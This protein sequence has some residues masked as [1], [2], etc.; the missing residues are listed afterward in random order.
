MNIRIAKSV[1][2]A[3]L[4]CGGG[5]LLSANETT[6]LDDIQVVTTASG[7]EQ[8][9]T[10]A[11]AS[12]SVI[13]QEDLQKKSFTSILDAVANIEGVDINET[14]DKSGQGSISIRGMGGNYTLILI[15]GKR[16]NNNGGLYP[17]GNGG[18]QSANI[19]PQ[20]M[21]ERVEV[22]RGPMSTLYGADAMGGVINIIT[23]K[24]TKTWTGSINH[25]R[26]FQGER[27]W[28]DENSTDFA[29]S[30]PIIKDKLGLSLRG[31]YLDKDRGNPEYKVVKKPDGTDEDRNDTVWNADGKTLDTK[32]YSLGAGLTFTPTDV[33]TI[34]VDYDINKQRYDHSGEE[35]GPVDSLDWIFDT[36]K[37][38]YRDIQRMEREQYSAS[39]E[40]DWDIG[41]S[42]LLIHHI[43]TN[44]FG[45]SMPLSPED[46]L[47]IVNKYPSS[48]GGTNTRPN[49]NVLNNAQYHAD[50]AAAMNDPWF[51]AFMPRD[52]RTLK[53]ETT[54]Y[55]AKYELPL[56]S[57]F[58]TV[59]TEYLDREMA[60]GIWSQPGTLNSGGAVQKA[61]QWAVFAEDNW[62]IIDPLTL[63]LGARYTKDENFGGHFSPRAYL[64]YSLNDNWTFKGGV[65]TGYKTPELQQLVD[66]IMYYSGHGTAPAVGNPNLDPETSVN[67]EAAVYYNH[68]DGHNFNVTLFQN[69]FKDKIETVDLAQTSDNFLL[70]DVWKNNKDRLPTAGKSGNTAYQQLE[71]VGKAT[72][73]GIEIAGKYYI[74]DNLS[75][76][77]N[78]TFL[79]TE[80]K[81]DDPMVDGR[82]FGNAPKHKYGVTLAYQI[83]SD[84]GTYLEYQGEK[85]R[86]NSRIV[87]GTN[88]KDVNYKDYKVVNLGGSYKYD[89]NMTFNAR[90]NNL[91]NED[92]TEYSYGRLGTQDYRNEYGNKLSGRNFFV[93]MNYSF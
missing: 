25:G 87:S 20:S 54:T 79:D 7:Y 62:A 32:N 41:K 18:M 59:G 46:R 3:L 13:T 55:S 5:N 8:K 38:G 17:N 74:L 6:K 90:V 78:Y 72:L 82:P 50:Y 28:G 68:E 77:L 30:G 36:H 31:S 35:I 43:E 56:N 67:Y 34:K 89:K 39:Y 91:L 11:P 58:I 49:G 23:K 26:T 42:T 44:N 52:T 70:P 27:K 47:A 45:R 51:Q 33:D 14:Q 64:A 16:Q 37:V 12:I 92:F 60:D 1:A 9:L 93:S 19:P 80:L 29:I 73:R 85:D 83:T 57:H 24:T 22:I 2:T 15:D 84:I 4:V 65:S 53:S 10:D 88:Y 40:R 61:Y 76:K 81:S 63:T 48:Y 75:F 21:I 86:F 66:G 69:D 71:N